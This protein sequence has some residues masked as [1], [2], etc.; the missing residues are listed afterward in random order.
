MNIKI[1][2]NITFIIFTLNKYIS[3]PSLKH[4]Q[5]LKKLYKYLLEAKL[6]L[7]YIGILEIYIIS[8]ISPNSNIYLNTYNDLDWGKDKN[9]YYSIINYFFK[10]AGEAIS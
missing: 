7:K 6:A 9:N 10:I 5:A 2:L 3:N 1:Q 8:E 4:F